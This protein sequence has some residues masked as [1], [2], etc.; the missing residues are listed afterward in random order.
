[1]NNNLFEKFNY[2]YFI[3]IGGISMSGL[4]ELMLDEGCKVA[5]SDKCSS[6]IIEKLKK[7]GAEIFIEHNEKNITEDIDLVVYTSAISDDNPEL[8]MAKKLKLNIMDRAEFLGYIMKGYTHSICVSGTHGKTTT[9]GM[10]SSILLETDLEPTIFLGGEMDS[11]GGNLKQG[12]NNLLLTE[13]CE[14]RRNFLKFNPTMELIL[15]I[16]SDHL[17]YYKDLKDIEEAFAEYAEKLPETG[18]LIA[19][20]VNVDIFKNVKCNVVTFGLTQEADFYPSDINYYPTPSYTLMNGDKRI[21]DINLKVY[22]EHNILNSIAAAAAC[23]M[24]D[25]DMEIIK[26]GLSEFKGTHRRYEFKGN[27]RGAVLI[28]DYAHHPAEMKTSLHTASTYSRGKII[29]VF[30]PH[31]YTRTKA[32]L[33]EFADVLKLSDISILLDIYAAR[34]K[35]NGTIHSKDLLN[36]LTDASAKGFYAKSFGEAVD[37]INNMV[38]EGDTLIIMGAGN[39]NEIIDMLK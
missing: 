7:L 12:A 36:K 34:E 31:T 38:T 5:G 37:L 21:A 9:T 24:L 15:N 20:H 25:I 16:D 30:Q 18:F 26:K 6:H 32:L 22:G 2:I 19:N 11:L 39:V 23:I 14:Y 8:L 10:L 29:T 17:D 4:A 28:E 33:N 3:G 35:D 13:A 27:Y 1:M